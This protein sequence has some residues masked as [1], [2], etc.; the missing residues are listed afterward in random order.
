MNLITQQQAD[1][2]ELLFATS[3][4]RAAIEAAFKP[5]AGRQRTS[6][7]T[8]AAHPVPP[9]PRADQRRIGSRRSRLLEKSSCLLRAY[10]A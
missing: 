8:I 4:V 5:C 6:A 2:F 3:K 1:H 10:M 9:P 7:T